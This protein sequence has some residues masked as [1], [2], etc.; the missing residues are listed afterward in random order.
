MKLV[1]DDTRTLDLPDEMSD[2]AARQLKALILAHEERTRAAESEVRLL[3]DEMAAMRAMTA[4]E[5]NDDS[6][7]IAELRAMRQELSAGLRRVEQVAG[8][9]R[10]VVPDPITGEMTRSR[11]ILQRE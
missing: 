11:V 1:L 6:Q 10:M 5:S 9:D 2:E 4:S 7:V 3:R 8:A